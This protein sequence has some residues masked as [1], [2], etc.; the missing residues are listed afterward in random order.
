MSQSASDATITYA[1]TFGGV[2]LPTPPASRPGGVVA[3]NNT[4]IVV[5]VLA[6]VAVVAAIMFLPRPK[7]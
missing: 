2:A 4:G 6:G 7:K 5:A 3:A 1:P